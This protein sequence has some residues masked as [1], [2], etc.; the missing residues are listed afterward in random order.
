MERLWEDKT[1]MRQREMRNATAFCGFHKVWSD[2]DGG[3][4]G[5]TPPT[6]R[7]NLPTPA[8]VVMFGFS[9][10]QYYCVILQL[11]TFSKNKRIIL[12]ENGL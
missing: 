9:V 2:R 8:L 12:T 6:R 10:L 4:G 3:A 5:L 7:L 1:D 11:S